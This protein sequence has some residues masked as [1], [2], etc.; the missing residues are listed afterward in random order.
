EQGDPDAI[1]WPSP[2]VPKLDPS[3]R[4]MGELDFRSNAVS[5]ANRTVI[6]RPVT[7]QDIENIDSLALDNFSCDFSK[8]E[9]PKG[10]ID[11]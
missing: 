4:K 1:K 11:D 6:E 7:A 9:V 10:D 8:I 5:E 3:S 2:E